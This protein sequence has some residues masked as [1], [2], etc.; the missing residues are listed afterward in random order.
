LIEDFFSVDV[1]RTSLFLNSGRQNGNKV[2]LF[3]ILQ[4]QSG[5]KH[6]DSDHEEERNFGRN[7]EK[8]KATATFY[9]ICVQRNFES[10]EQ[11]LSA[12]CAI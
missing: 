10:S 12:K 2:S 3:L 4:D 9:D 5:T 1:K 8:R 6:L 7:K 11:Y